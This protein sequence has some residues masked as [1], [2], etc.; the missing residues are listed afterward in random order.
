MEVIIMGEN[1]F[2]QKFNYSK[3]SNRKQIATTVVASFVSA[4]VGGACALGVYVGLNKEPAKALETS[5]TNTGSIVETSNPNLSQVSLTNYSDTAIYAA[6]K[7]LPSMVSISVEYDVNYMGMKKPVAGSGSGV[8]L[9]EDGYILTNNHVISSADSSSF[10]QVSDAKSIKVKIY[11]DDTEYSAEIIGT[12]SQTDLAVL[13][14]DK[15]GLTPAELGDSSSVQIGEFVL[16][17][18]NPYNL[19]YSVT[20]GII[21]ALNREMTVENTT[22]NVIQADCAINSGNSGGA[23][24]NSK[25]EVIG[26]TTL[27]LAGDGIEGVSFAIPVNETVPIYKELIEKGKISRPFVGISGIDLDEATAIRNGL[28]KGIYVDSVVSGSGAEDAGIMAGDV[29]VSF[30]GKDVSTMDELNAIKNTKNIG[31]KI[32]IKLY[33]K[34][35]LKTFTITLKEAE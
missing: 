16:A 11:G 6:Q 28:T 29:I 15:T 13:K 24:V 17:I 27:K 12:D 3:N 35:E 23:L 22:Y 9:S 32:E 2:V 25:G 26:I 18:G 8:I 33:R 30:D 7:A 10:Y 20:A 19:D 5:K 14:I 4:V 21:S 1:D 34:S 31:D